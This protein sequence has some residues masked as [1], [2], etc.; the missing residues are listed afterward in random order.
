MDTATPAVDAQLNKVQKVINELR[1]KNT[2]LSE[3]NARLKEQ[4][5]NSKSSSTRIRRI[6][7]KTDAVSPEI[8][9]PAE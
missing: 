9:H 6:P 2:Q 5:R 1:K 7:K 3:D 8:E 4:V